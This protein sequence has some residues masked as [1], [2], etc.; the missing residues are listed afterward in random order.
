VY[1][2]A[3]ASAIGKHWLGTVVTAEVTSEVQLNH[4]KLVAGSGKP[5]QVPLETL[6]E[7]PVVLVPETVGFAVTTGVPVIAGVEAVN[8]TVDPRECVAVIRATRCL[9]TSSVV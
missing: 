7:L 8:L 1:E 4:W 9:P 5:T 2:L 3:V 6:R